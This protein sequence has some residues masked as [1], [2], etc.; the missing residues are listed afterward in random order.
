MEALNF[1]LKIKSF[2][3]II[4]SNFSYE[5]SFFLLLRYDFGFEDQYSYNEY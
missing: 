3:L 5:N 1:L 4:F 2:L